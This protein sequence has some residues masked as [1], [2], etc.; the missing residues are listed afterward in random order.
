MYTSSSIF[1][2]FY[3]FYLKYILT[4]VISKFTKSHHFLEFLK[5]WYTFGKSLVMTITHV[6]GGWCRRHHHS[7]WFAA[8]FFFFYCISSKE[9]VSGIWIHHLY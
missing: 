8:E 4:L 1:E 6:V 7:K 2:Q 5:K 3:H 9:F